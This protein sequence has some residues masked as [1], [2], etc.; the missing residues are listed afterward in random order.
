MLKSI[1]LDDI[2]GIVVIDEVGLHLY[3]SLQRD[4]LPKPIKRFPK[5]QFIITYHS[6][7]FILGMEEACGTDGYE[8]IQMPEGGKIGEKCFQNF[9]RR[10]NILQ[11]LRN[12]KQ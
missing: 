1:K 2:S 7:L 10:M 5:V 3:S 6:P 8:L 11:Q 4:I 9:K 12:I